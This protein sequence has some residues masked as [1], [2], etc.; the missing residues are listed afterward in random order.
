M[1]D[2]TPSER[3]L[4]DRLLSIAIS[5]IRRRIPD[6]DER[7]AADPDYDAIVNYVE[8]NAVARVLNNP[9]GTSGSSYE[10]I[11]PYSIRGSGDNGY[12]GF[13]RLLPDEWR[14]LGVWQ[15]GNAF[16]IVPYMK[17]P[18]WSDLGYHDCWN[19]GF[20]CAHLHGSS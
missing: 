19:D 20:G 9:G 10:T 4:S 18:E 13:F 12:S 2:L 8:A 11:G 5:M 15:R 17:K 14:L 3:A 1:R 6:V 16:T 7:M